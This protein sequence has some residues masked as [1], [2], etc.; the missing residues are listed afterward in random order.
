[1][2]LCNLRTTIQQSTFIRETMGCHC[3]HLPLSVNSENAKTSLSQF[4]SLYS[5]IHPPLFLLLSYCYL[6]S[7]RRDQSLSIQVPLLYTNIHTDHIP[8][9]SPLLVTWTAYAKIGI[10]EFKSVYSS[11]SQPGGMSP[12]GGNGPKKVGNPSSTVYI[13]IIYYFFSSPSIEQRT[14]RA[15]SLN[16]SQSTAACPNRG[17]L[18][19]RWGNGPKKVGNSRSTVYIHIISSPLCHLNSVRQ[20]RY[21]WIQVSL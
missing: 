15:V 19:P 14:Q 9:P 18:S 6:N 12:R 13:H 8:F 2:T 7:V 20:E 21:L 5:T 1:M 10:S 3:E 11:G 16:S 4:K 17:G